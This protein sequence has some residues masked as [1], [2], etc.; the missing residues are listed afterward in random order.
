[1]AGACYAL[2]IF[3]KIR[4]IYG[5]SEKNVFPP[6]DKSIYFLKGKN[7]VKENSASAT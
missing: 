7:E 5:F 4:H 3:V 1:L 6:L 2:T